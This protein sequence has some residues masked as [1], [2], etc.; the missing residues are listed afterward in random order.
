MSK[1]WFLSGTEDDLIEKLRSGDEVYH[2]ELYGQWRS[3]FIKWSMKNYKLSHNEASSLYQDAF[4]EFYLTLKRRANLQVQ[5][6]KTFFYS[7]GKNIA[8]SQYRERKLLTIEESESEIF[9]ENNALNHTI[10]SETKKKIRSL[11]NGFPEPCKSILKMYYFNGF[12]HDI[13]A[14]R[15][16]YKNAG[17]MKKKKS[18]CMSSL[19]EKFKSLDLSLF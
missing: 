1:R 19:R 6:P 9:T 18:L 13:I 10:E 5:H 2:K 11:V 8:M 7:I 4:V 15:L 16:G 12:S 14:E 17:V 3:G